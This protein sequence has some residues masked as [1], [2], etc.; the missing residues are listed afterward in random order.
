MSID[1]V[2][3]LNR[4]IDI[5]THKLTHTHTYGTVKGLGP[6]GLVAVVPSLHIHKYSLTQSLYTAQEVT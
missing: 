1:Q 3:Q 6:W 2:F 4:I 5:H